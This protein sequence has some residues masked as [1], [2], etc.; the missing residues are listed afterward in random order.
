MILSQANLNN[1]TLKDGNEEDASAY[2]D[3]RKPE[4]EERKLNVVLKRE[5]I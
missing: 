4:E 2:G 5:L 3:H 1:R